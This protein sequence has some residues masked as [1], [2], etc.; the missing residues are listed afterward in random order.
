MKKLLF[1]LLCVPLMFSCG[2]GDKEKKE[3]LEVVQSTD[4]GR[5][6]LFKQYDIIPT[7]VLEQLR[8]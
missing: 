2:G 6:D 4:E 8:N 3:K 7:S 5:D 1:I